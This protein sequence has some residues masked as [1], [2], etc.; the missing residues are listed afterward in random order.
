MSDV[1]HMWE[2]REQVVS[3]SEEFLM[4]KVTRE[5]EVI[6]KEVEQVQRDLRAVGFNVSAVF[7]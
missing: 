2:L 3:K 5:C 4:A 1:I 6:T 7:F